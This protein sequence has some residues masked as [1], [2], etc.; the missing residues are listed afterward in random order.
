MIGCKWRQLTKASKENVL[1]LG[2]SHRCTDALAAAAAVR[3]LK[4]TYA[5]RWKQEMQ[6]II[7]KQNTEFHLERR[8]NDNA[9]QLVRNKR[10]TALFPLGRIIV[11]PFLLGC[12]QSLVCCPCCAPHS[13]VFKY[14]EINLSM[15]SETSCWI[16]GDPWDGFRSSAT[17]GLTSL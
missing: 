17:N 6:Q 16:S 12:G 9:A 15:H 5:K 10:G 4:L 11:I 3:E 1:K 14:R 7:Q 2:R 13:A 8:M